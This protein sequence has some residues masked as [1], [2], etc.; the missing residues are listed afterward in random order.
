MKYNRFLLI[1]FVLSSCGGGGGGGGGIPFA[2]TIASNSFS[3]NEDEI[4]SGSLSASANEVVTLSYAVTSDTSNGTI[5]LTSS[6]AITYT[7]NSNF[8]GSDQFSFSVNASEKNVTQTATAN[9]TINAVNDA[10]TITMDTYSN[11]NK[12]NLIFESN[13]SYN[14]TY[15]DIDNDSA[16][17]TFSASVDDQD[18]PS[19]FTSISEGYGSIELDLS[20]ITKSGF[21]NAKLKISDGTASTFTAFDTWFI[22][23]KDTVTISQDDDKNDGFI[24][25]SKTE[26]DYYVYELIGD[27]NSTAGTKWLFVADSLAD[28]SDVTAFRTA[29]LESINLLNESDATTFFAGY[30]DIVVAEPVS[31][32]GTSAASIETGCYDWDEDVYCIGSSDI[33]TS[34]FQ[35][36][37]ADNDLIS[38]LSMQPGRGVNLGKTNIQQI[39]S[40]TSV[41]VMHELGHAHGEMGDEYR[42]DDDRDVSSFADRNINTTTQN[43]VSLLKWNHHI[44]DQT[45]VLGKDT[46]VCYNYGDGT[47]GDWDDRGITVDQCG[48]FANEW[49]SSPDSNGRYSF[50][51]KNPECGKVGLFEGNYYGKY[52]NYRPTFCSVM[53]SCSSGGYGKVNV[54]G[55]AIGSIINQGFE[56]DDVGFVSNTGSSSNDGFQISLNVEYDQSKI[57][58]EWYRNGV[59]D[60]AKTDQ[61]SVTFAR[62]A[63]NSVEVYT[64]RA[65][66]LTGYVT[67]PDDVNNHDDFYEGLFNSSFI[68][69]DVPNNEWIYNPQ[70][71]SLYNY[72]YMFGPLGG[73]WAINWA[74]Y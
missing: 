71:Q 26:K 15:S 67:A 54:E 1:L 37:L 48:C 5:N 65:V 52:N 73:K 50:I 62:P 46:L 45:N 8:F 18:I 16:D 19:V 7:P 74:K 17:F 60:E 56:D 61:K 2:I 20:S 27:T 14:V 55:F 35:D 25:G 64:W 59:K 32:D 47:I 53:D 28:D 4:Y 12:D 63:D 51:R 29:L 23:N 11:L 41:T 70:D 68:W 72:G 24:E 69:R 42:S 43:D 36:L 57:T 66:D 58:L 22:A 13:P 49:S 31:P 21:L 10:P 40:S 9:I 34:I 39:K 44:E 33:N 30:F 3:V 6:G 38:V